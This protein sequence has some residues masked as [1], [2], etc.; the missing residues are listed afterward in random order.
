MASIKVLRMVRRAGGLT[1]E[2][3]REAWLGEH[4]PLE[5]KVLEAHVQGG[6]LISFA[7]GEMLGGDQPPF[8][9]MLEIRLRHATD[10]AAV[11]A[12]LGSDAIRQVEATLA[13]ASAA[14]PF[15]V[16]EEHLMSEN[17]AW[18]AEAARTCVPRTKVV[19][20]IRRRPD[21]TLQ[22]FKDYWLHQHSRLEKERTETTRVRRI[23]ATFPL[24]GPIG[25]EG[26][27]PPFDGMVA[28]YFEN[29]DAAKRQ[30]AATA[31]SVMRQDEV[32]FVDMSEAPLRSITEEYRIAGPSSQAFGH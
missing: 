14:L 12:A 9:A 25:A 30:F 23:V 6:I 13:D 5:A 8:D 16:A 18:A 1:R 19:R 3:F 32:N 28:L 15:L 4:P 20:T 31:P 22:Q 10:R 7:T 11:I 17:A 29:P 24:G 26:A 27:Q 2:Q 21:L